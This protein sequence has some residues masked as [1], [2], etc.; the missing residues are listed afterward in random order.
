[1]RFE[2][3]GNYIEVSEA[4]SANKGRQIVCIVES[5]LSFDKLPIN[6]REQISKSDSTGVNNLKE[7]VSLWAKKNG[8]K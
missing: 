7:S 1:M 2:K 5:S 8:Y 6:F 3:D 4:L